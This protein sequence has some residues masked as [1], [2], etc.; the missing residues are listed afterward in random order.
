M[1]KMNGLYRPRNGRM[2]AGVAAGLARRF[3]LPVWLV[4]LGWLLLFLPGGL[5]GL[6]PYIIFWIFMP[7]E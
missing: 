2:L 6:V 5:P 1:F 7:S 4:R 3:G